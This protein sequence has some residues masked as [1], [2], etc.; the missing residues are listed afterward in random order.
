MK[1]Y[2]PHFVSGMLVALSAPLFAEPVEDNTFRGHDYARKASH[3]KVAESEQ[4][5]AGK[6]DALQ[7]LMHKETNS[8]RSGHNAETHHRLLVDQRSWMAYRDS[9]C[10]LQS[11]VYVYPVD[12]RMSQSEYNACTLGMNLERIHFLDDLKQEYNR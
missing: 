2:V 12:S 7:V 4:A 1:K 8:E 5:L 11:Y 6:L 3:D 9:H 10:W